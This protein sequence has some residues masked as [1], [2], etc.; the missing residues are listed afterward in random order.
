MHADEL[1]RHRRARNIIEENRV[2]V[3]LQ[4][5]LVENFDYLD[6]E[7]RDQINCILGD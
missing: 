7:Y 3:A 4:S 1:A 2:K 5:E 6:Q